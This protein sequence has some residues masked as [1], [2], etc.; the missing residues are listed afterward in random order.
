MNTLHSL[1]TWTL[2]TSLRASLLAGAVMLIQLAL[3]GHISARWRYALWLPVLFV[4]LAPVLPQ[5]RWSVESI[6]AP[7]VIAPAPMPKWSG[8]FTPLAPLPMPAL[9]AEETEPAAMASVDWQQVLMLAWLVGVAVCW[10]GGIG[11]YLATMR[12][13]RR[14]ALAP[15][16]ALITRVNALSDSVKL[17]RAPR[18]LVSP[19]I[20]SPA[21][22]G[23]WRPCGGLCCCCQRTSRLPSPRLRPR[24]C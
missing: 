13:F 18:L 16:T 21:V 17:R 1:F 20:D 11:F 7:E 8:E 10:C 3:R 9:G 2:D 23:L 19:R 4:L 6:L 15:D 12:R 14:T 24:S 22:A 5:S